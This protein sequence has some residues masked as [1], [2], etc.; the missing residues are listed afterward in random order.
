MM[1]STW[2][3]S[4]IT[5]DVRSW[6]CTHGSSAAAISRGDATLPVHASRR[7]AA[8]KGTTR[9]HASHAVSASAALHAALS[10]RKSGVAPR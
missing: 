6:H 10:A 7:T 2:P 3:T 9:R 1:P 8:R 4:C 5:T